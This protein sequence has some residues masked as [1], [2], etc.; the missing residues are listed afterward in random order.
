MSRPRYVPQVGQTWWGILR[1]RHRSQRTSVGASSRQLAARRRDVR[2][3]ESL[4]FGTATIHV[5]F[6]T[7]KC[8]PCSFPLG[9]VL[10]FPGRRSSRAGL[11]G[12]YR[13]SPAKPPRRC[14]SA[15]RSRAPSRPTGSSLPLPSHVHPQSRRWPQT[16][17]SPG[18]SSLHRGRTGRARMTH[19]S[20]VG[21]RFTCSRYGKT[22]SSS[23]SS[24][25]SASARAVSE[26]NRSSGISRSSA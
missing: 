24:A 20:I 10:S 21:V 17:H 1:F 19:S 25:C 9:T 2:A 23:Q 7:P 13:D 14:C 3:F 15:S 4:R 12:P 5:P 11:P 22:A 16:G 6:R 8:R 18:Q 26:R